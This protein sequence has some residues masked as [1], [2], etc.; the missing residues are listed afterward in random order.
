MGLTPF[1]GK[2]VVAVG[3]EIPGVAGGLQKALRTEPREFHQG[4]H[5]F[6]VFELV[7]QKV[8]HQPIDRE[9][10]GGPQERVH[11]FVADGATFVDGSIVAEHLEQQRVR[12][13]EAAGVHRLQLDGEDDDGGE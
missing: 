2:D 7:T 9:N 3:L 4:E 8:R 11:I 1:E 10:P 13:E 6:A 12:N 5:A